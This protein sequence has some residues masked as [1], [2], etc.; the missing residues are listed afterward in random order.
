[1]AVLAVL[2]VAIS[3]SGGPESLQQVRKQKFLR[4]P[5]PSC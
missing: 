3:R 5:R 2:V 4:S 1:M